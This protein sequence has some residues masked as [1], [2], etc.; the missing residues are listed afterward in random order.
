MPKTG[1]PRTGWRSAREKALAAWHMRRPLNPERLA[2]RYKRMVVSFVKNA[3]VVY[4]EITM[5][6]SLKELASIDVVGGKSQK[7]QLK[8]FSFQ[9]DISPEESRR[10]LNYLRSR[11][12][13][14]NM[15][16]KRLSDLGKILSSEA[17]ISTG[18]RKREIEK[19]IGDLEAFNKRLLVETN[20]RINILNALINS[21]QK[22]LESQAERS[23]K[24]VVFEVE[25]PERLKGQ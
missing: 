10:I 4:N 2:G 24:P 18:E 1:K 14:L 21:F 6:T 5:L 8:S 17:R 25:L 13:R 19:T 15:M 23:S 3:N 22:F 16:D 20:R 11:S 12:A 7:G 9:I